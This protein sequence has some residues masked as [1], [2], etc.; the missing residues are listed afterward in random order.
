MQS[1]DDQKILILQVELFFIYEKLK[2]NKYI[3]LKVDQRQANI[4]HDKKLC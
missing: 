4:L 3:F 1:I 2:T